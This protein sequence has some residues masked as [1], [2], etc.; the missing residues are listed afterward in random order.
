MKFK[1]YKAMFKKK[2][3]EPDNEEVTESLKKMEEGLNVTNILIAREQ[4]KLEVNL[5]SL[6]CLYLSY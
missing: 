2:L 4:A 5:P 6:N 3:E 1:A